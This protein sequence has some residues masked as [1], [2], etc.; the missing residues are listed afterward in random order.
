RGMG[1]G[2][3]TAY[4][5]VD[6]HDG[7]ITV[8]SQAGVGTTFHIFLP[9]ARGQG[10]GQ[11]GEAPKGG[12]GSRFKGR[13]LVMDDEEMLRE[14]AGKMLQRLGY[15]VALTRDG[16]EAIEVYKRAMD[17][18]K[19][20]DAVILDLTVRGGMGGKEAVRKLKEIDPKV[21]AIVSSGYSDNPV[22][23]N[24]QQFGFD[25]AM[26]KPY[27]KLDLMRVLEKTVQQASS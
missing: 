22:M 21:K 8:A 7:R 14:L 26:E 2:L 20:F 4:S 1:L 19:P 27:Q 13:L 18:G 10:E 24:W 6:K 3:A 9:A 23:T 11:R 17:A 12:E 16:A 15:E 5:I 25:G